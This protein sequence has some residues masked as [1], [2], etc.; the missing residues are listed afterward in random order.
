M[1]T[2]ISKYKSDYNK[3]VELGNILYNSIQYACYPEKFQDAVKKL[4]K[5]EY[6]DYLNSLP[7]FK[8][9]YQTWYSESKILIKQLLPDRLDVSCPK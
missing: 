3:L 7:D 4:Y 9:K 6:L 2:N 1:N 8:S 5:E